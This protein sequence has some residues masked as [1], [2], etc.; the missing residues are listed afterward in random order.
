MD[1]R[2]T[3]KTLL[4]GAV[5]GSTIGIGCKVSNSEAKEAKD[6][7]A[8]PVY[9]RTPSEQKHDQQVMALEGLNAHEAATIAVLV[10][11]ILPATPTAGSATAAKVPEFI[12]FIIRDLPSYH[13]LKIRGGLM[14][15]DGETNRRFNKT[16]EQASNAEQLQIIEDIAYPD[17]DGKKPNLSHGIQFFNHLRNLTLTGYYTTRMGF[18]DLGYKGNTPNVWDGVPAD[19]LKDHDVDY[20]AEWIAKCVDQSKRD[21]IAEWDAEGNLLT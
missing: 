4:V 5:A 3:L 14:W 6:S 19:V 7:D 15:L 8:L 9:G 21:I 2:D 16:F 10:D 1:R 17:P 11:I 13:D 20:D 12:D 18:D